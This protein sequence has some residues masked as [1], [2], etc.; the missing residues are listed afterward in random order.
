[1]KAEERDSGYVPTTREEIDRK[2]FSQLESLALQLDQGKITEAQ[3]DTGVRTVWACVSGLCSQHIDETISAIKE[4]KFQ[5]RSFQDVR[6][7]WK[8]KSLVISSRYGDTI[9]TRGMTISSCTTPNHKNFNDEAIPTKAALSYQ[10]RF[11]AGLESSG[12]MQL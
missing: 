11:E 3:F 6:L 7:Y 10:N 1:M 12:Y 5:D 9:T 8:G 2:A 4:Q